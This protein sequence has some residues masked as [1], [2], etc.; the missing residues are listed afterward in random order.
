MHDFEALQHSLR[1]F[2]HGCLLHSLQSRHGWRRLC[3]NVY[4]HQ[5]KPLLIDASQEVLH[6]SMNGNN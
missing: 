5:P 2:L 3:L 4:V 6:V 1:F